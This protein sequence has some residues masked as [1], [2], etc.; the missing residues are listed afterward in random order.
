MVLRFGFDSGVR[1]GGL[2]F[3]ARLSGHTGVCCTHQKNVTLQCN[4]FSGSGKRWWVVCV[5]V[6]FYHFLSNEM[7][8]SSC[9]LLSVWF[10]ITILPDPEQFCWTAGPLQLQVSSITA[11]FSSLSLMLLWEHVLWALPRLDPSN[12]DPLWGGASNNERAIGSRT[13][14]STLIRPGL[15]LLKK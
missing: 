3:L 6:C 4:G 15:V 10:L 12:R 2:T 14:Q 8:C 7:V 1:P 13:T 11:S 5:C 9:K